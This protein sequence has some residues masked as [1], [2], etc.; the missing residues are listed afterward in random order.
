[1][2][3]GGG[4]SFAVTA[5]SGCT[6]VNAG[7]FN[8]SIDSTTFD[9]SITI[10]NFSVGDTLTFSFSMSGLATA[11]N[12]FSGSSA[13]LKA[14][15]FSSTQTYTVTGTNSDTTL[16]SFIQHDATF[17]GNV[18][19]TATC[20]ASSVAASTTSLNSSLN[21]SAFG[22]PVT[23]TATVTGSS[24]TGTVTFKDGANTL[25]TGTLNGSGV[26]TFTT[27]SLTLGSHSITASY[28]GDSNNS[29]STS[30]PLT[31]VVNAASTTTTLGSSLNPSSFG[32]A[33]T[34]TATV[35]GSSPTGTVTFYDGGTQI[36]TGTLSGGIATFTISSLALGKHTI[37]A[38]YG[39]DSNNSASTSSALTQTVGIPADS[40]KLRQMQLLAT[41]V[42][43]QISGQAITGAIETAIED[44]F[45]DYV[46]PFTPNGSG[47]TFHFAADELNDPR[48][49]SGS[50]G[51]KRFIAAPD[52]RANQLIDDEFSALGYAGNITKAPPK[53]P[54]LQRDWL[55]WIDVRGV[56]VYNNSVGNDL[57]GNQVNLTAGLTRKLT[58]NF[59]VGA[60]GGYEHL[61]YNSDALNSRLKGDGWTVGSYLGWRFAESLRFDMA[62]AHSNIGYNDTSGMAAATFPG[63]R[64]LASGGLTGTY[65]LQAL[66]LQP[67]VRVYGLWEHDSAYTDNLGI[68]WG[69]NDFSTGRASAGTKLSYPFVWSSTINLA[70]YVGVY[71]DYYF[72]SSNAAVAGV[73][74]LPLQLQG[75]SARFTS[76]VTMKFA[77]GGLIS[78]GG[79]LGGIGG[80][81]T[82]WTYRLQGSVP[83]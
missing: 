62:L 18:S 33:V 32:Q 1:V 53:N 45:S 57:K 59:I 26:A 8:D 19:V 6:A 35:T 61:D 4:Q 55:A 27:S 67:S 38:S 15:I 11:W 52:R 24:P 5:S 17:P 74:T 25:G 48:S 14:T 16:T 66:V 46:Q 29:A 65:H 78:L 54:T 20:T 51:L 58:P 21:P 41:P 68:A 34:F 23:F 30:S 77:N 28:A 83:F 72:S 82:V 2:I 3:A 60:F 10:S 43:A 44:A 47:F 75:W 50:D 56:S 13:V 9:H 69:T 81:T 64:W 79:E 37:T 63:S 39:G 42:A 70:P 49:S 76:G 71:G 12:L 73:P 80:N 7:G 31:Q 22:Q 40:L 36:G